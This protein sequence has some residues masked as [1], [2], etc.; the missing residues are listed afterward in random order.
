MLLWDEGFAQSPEDRMVMLF[1]RMHRC[2]RIIFSVNYHTGKWS[3]EQ[4]INFLVD[5]VGHE[6][7]NAEGKIRRSFEGGYEPLY[8]IGYMIGGLQ[9]MQL[10]R[11]LVDTKKMS[12]KAFHDDFIQQ[13]MMPIE[14]E[15]PYLKMNL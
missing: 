7:A 12:Y 4:C 10:K 14:M 1:W 5:S 3:P 9:I 11:E 15:R 6:R 2:A 8:Q 13:N